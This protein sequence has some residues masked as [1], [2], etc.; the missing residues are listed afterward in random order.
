[1]LDILFIFI[2]FWTPP[3]RYTQNVRYSFYI[4]YFSSCCIH[5]LEFGGDN[6]VRTSGDAHVF[7]KSQGE[8]RSFL[9]FQW[10]FVSEYL[11]LCLD[12]I[13]QW[14]LFELFKCLF[15]VQP[16]G[17]YS[18]LWLG[19]VKYPVFWSVRLELYRLSTSLEGVLR[20]YVIN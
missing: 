11:V 19:Q 12:L 2:T 7:A 20:S 16:L 3:Y 8:S 1:M 9:I 5:S 18:V 10:L 4:I 14:N 13:L 17:K 6:F 15:K